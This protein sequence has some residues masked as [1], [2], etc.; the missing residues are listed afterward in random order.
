MSLLRNATNE[1]PDGLSPPYTHLHSLQIS[2][3]SIQLEHMLPV[4]RLP[5]LRTLDIVAT[6]DMRH[7]FNS[8]IIT[9]MFDSSPITNLTIMCRSVSLETLAYL[10]AVC[11]ALTGFTFDYIQKYHERGRIYEISYP[12]LFKALQKH[13]KTLEKLSLDGGRIMGRFDA[14]LVDD[15][16]DLTLVGSLLSFEKLRQLSTPV[17]AFESS[18]YH[19][20]PDFID[21]DFLR[22]MVEFKE[23]LP[24]SLERLTL[25]VNGDEL[26]SNFCHSS[27]NML[28]LSPIK[29]D[30]PSL[31]EIKV[32]LHPM[33]DVKYVK[34]WFPAED[35]RRVGITSTI[36]Q[37]VN[38]RYCTS[39]IAGS[40]SG[41]PSDDWDEDDGER[42]YA[43]YFA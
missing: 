32:K 34:D 16:Y 27:L 41:M 17:E 12:R 35:L 7:D 3:S 14:V 4:F 13:S 20:Y 21:L 15:D 2:M 24:K 10:I 23:V 22:P 38:E 29:I 40:I 31:H 19:D 11:K 5:S 37:V 28:Y 9:A 18:L 8:G 43:A 1:T 39:S 42:Y 6:M 25:I 36:S 30:F 26:S 33:I